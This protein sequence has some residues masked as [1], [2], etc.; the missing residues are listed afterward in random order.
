MIGRTF[1]K[2]SGSS[3]RERSDRSGASVSWSLV[4]IGRFA[5]VLICPSEHKNTGANNR[6]GLFSR[7]CLSG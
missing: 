5:P 7:G 3:E 1:Q 4:E 6:A 2:R